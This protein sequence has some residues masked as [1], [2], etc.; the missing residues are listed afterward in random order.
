MK[1]YRLSKRKIYEL[2]IQNIKKCKYSGNGIEKLMSVAAK[3]TRFI[4]VDPRIKFAGVLKEGKMDLSF[5]N[6]NEHL[7]NNNAK[8][9]CIQTPHIIEIGE[10]FSDELGKLEY[11][12]FEYDK[13]KI[14]DLTAKEKTVT[15]AT[16]KDADDEEIVKK[17]S[18]HILNPENRRQ[19]KLT[20]R[21]SMKSN[22]DN[23]WQKP[24]VKLHKIYERSSQ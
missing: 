24:Y 22:S 8:L 18:N 5:K 15:F 6:P 14:F 1:G 13:L 9:G 19:V 17:I 11:I 7:D 23:L 4:K 10:R 16:T 3:F 2:N 20:K 12:S 21:M